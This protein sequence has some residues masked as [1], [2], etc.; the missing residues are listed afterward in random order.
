MKVYISSP[1]S[2]YQ[3][4]WNQNV[5]NILRNSGITVHL[6]QEITVVGQKHKNFE[7][8]VYDKCIE[9]MDDSDLGILLLPYGRDCAYEIGY[10]RGLNKPTVMFVEKL[11]KVNLERLRDWMIKGSI[12]YIIC[13]SH[14]QKSILQNDPIISSKPIYQIDS[15]DEFPETI[16]SI[17]SYSKNKDT[18]FIGAGAVLIKEDKVLLV[19][20]EESSLDYLRT[21]GMWGFPTTKVQDH[22]PRD[23]AMISLEKEAGVIGKNPKFICLQNI[24]R[25]TGIFYKTEYVN[26]VD[27]YSKA[28]WFSINSVIKGNLFLRPTYDKV[29]K[30]VIKLGYI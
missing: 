11:N 18:H 3:K 9:W 12:D 16:K 24:P 8:H 29:L 13:I 30:N 1:V 17:I 6:P 4:D 23:Q 20:E 26:Q 15:F 27:N 7:K 5:T 25:A 19:Q 21:K 22:A 10:Y 28:K 14:K 2:Y